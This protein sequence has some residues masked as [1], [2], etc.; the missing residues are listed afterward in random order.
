MDALKD[1]ALRL[2]EREPPAGP[3]MAPAAYAPGSLPDL[4]A[5]LSCPDVVP[6]GPLLASLC[7]KYSLNYVHP[8]TCGQ[9]VSLEAV[10]G[11]AG[12]FVRRRG[13]CRA[14]AGRQ[15]LR[16]VLL[17]QGFALQMLFDLPKTVHLL[18][19][20]LA[21]PIEAQNGHGFFGLDLGAGTGILLLG[22]H[23]LARRHG[24]A[25]PELW[26]VEHL[27]RVAGRADGLLRRLG[28]GRVVCGDATDPALYKT[29]P[30]RPVTCLT[31]E[32]LPS[33][34]RRLYKEPFPAINAALFAALGPHLAATVFLP[35]AVWASDR[36]GT[37]G[38]RLAPENAFAGP[39]AGRPVRLLFMGDVELGG[40]RWPVDRVGEPYADLPATP[41]REVL[42]RRW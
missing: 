35:G 18:A 6:T 4:L 2:L 25:R 26:G 3:V 37:D 10:T 8:D 16:R 32:T 34:G 24:Y 21:C 29:L 15:N 30:D 42:G 38:V 40:R 31:N 33:R 1:L 36:P 28:V 5:E 13:G 19:T 39:A 11:L 7:L 20:L 27:P 9:P 17:E 23:L 14:L 22:Q 41:W 12:Q